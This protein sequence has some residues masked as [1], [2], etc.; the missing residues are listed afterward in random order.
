MVT[1]SAQEAEGIRLDLV[2]SALHQS[3]LAEQLYQG[4]HDVTTYGMDVSIR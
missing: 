3:G 2:A 1:L 4:L